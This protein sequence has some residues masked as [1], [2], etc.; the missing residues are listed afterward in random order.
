M[1]KELL[2]SERKKLG[3]TM[4]QA[5]ALCHVP[6]KTWQNWENGRRPIPAHVVVFIDY[7]RLSQQKGLQ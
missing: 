2:R 3:L 5:S 7:I 6:Y 4:T 1:N